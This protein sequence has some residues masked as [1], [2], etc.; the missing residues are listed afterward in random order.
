MLVYADGSALSRLVTDD[1]EAPAWAAWFAE[2][3]DDVITSPL[4]ITELRRAAFPLGPDARE[5]ARELAGTLTVV[6]FF[7]QALG[8]ASLASGV[9]PPFAAIH[10]GVAMAHA[11]VSTIAT[12]DA[13]LAQVAILHGLRV[14]AP[15]RDPEWWAG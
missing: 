13:Q 4:G 8:S 12:Y 9:L 11:D 10:L 14:I 7:D 5:R 1:V 2:H 15:G 3:A 6:R